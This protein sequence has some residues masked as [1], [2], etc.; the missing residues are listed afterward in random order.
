[1]QR[2]GKIS[3]KE[4]EELSEMTGIKS[5]DILNAQPGSILNAE[6]ALATRKIML[7]AANELSDYVATIGAKPTQQQLVT[8]RQLF[9]RFRGLQRSLAGFRSEAGRLLQSFSMEVVPNEYELMDDMIKKIAEIDQSGADELTKALKVGKEI[10]PD[11]LYQLAIKAGVETN[12]AFLLYNPPT[13][14]AN[15]IGNAAKAILRPAEKFFGEKISK[16]AGYEKGIVKGEAGAHWQGMK[17][18]APEAWAAFKDNFKDIVQGKEITGFHT[19]AEEVSRD[20]KTYEF[21]RKVGAP[22]KAAELADS[23]IKTSFKLLTAS[24]NYFRTINSGG[25]LYSQALR[26]GSQEGLTGKA[27]EKRVMDLM[28][29]PMNDEEFLKSIN[30]EVDTL[31]FQEDLPIGVKKLMGFRE[32]YPATKFIMFFTKTPFNIAREAIRTSPLG[33]LRPGF[34]K[35]RGKEMSEASKALA[36]AQASMGTALAGMTLLSVANGK[37]T[38]SAPADSGKRD[39][40]Y[41]S[42]KQ[43]YSVKIGDKWVSYRRLEPFA[44]IIAMTANTYETMTDDEIDSKAV[45]IA[46]LYYNN[47]TDQTFMKGIFDLNNAINDPNRYGDS[48]VRGQLTNKVPSIIG[49][50]ARAIDPTVRETNSLA[51]AFKA[52]TPGV[53]KSLP[54]KVDIFGKEVQREG[55]FLANFFTPFKTT[56]D[57]NDRTAQELEKSN[58]DLSVSSLSTIR[59]VKL[60]GKAKEMWLKAVG[61]A[62]KKELDKVVGS[63]YF[64]NYDQAKKDEVIK[65]TVE[66]VRDRY[67]S[68]VVSGELKY[69][70]DKRA[71]MTTT[72]KKKY[73]EEL[74]GKL[75]EKLGMTNLK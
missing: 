69:L 73:D 3:N 40:F 27:L 2:R 22:E 51:D 6:N 13:H 21:L 66:D 9:N 39:E 1:M 28:E 54:A 42:G 74:K 30:K 7:S 43:P 58:Y 56:T 37:I 72:E 16:A 34:S 71:K 10:K 36:Y 31:L 11:N 64:Q 20:R 55:G 70:L 47:I 14:V 44:T 12:T 25:E 49:H 8:F 24:D 53:S 38:G 35:M 19:K 59:G 18:A 52:I 17:D 29:N 61:Q 57:K 23:W 62:T 63:S 60:E 45:T 33:F 26:K 65:K 46:K 32:E 5:K 15:I 75:A 67:R 41:A 50:T 68:R 4:L 48:W